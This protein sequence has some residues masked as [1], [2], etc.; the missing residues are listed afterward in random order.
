MRLAIVG[1]ITHLYLETIWPTPARLRS[2]VILNSRSP[3]ACVFFFTCGFVASLCLRDTYVKYDG[4]QQCRT[5]YVYNNTL[6]EYAERLYRWYAF[7][8]MEKK[9]YFTSLAMILQKNV[10]LGVNSRRLIAFM[11]K[12]THL[13]ENTGKNSF[14]RLIFF[15][16]QLL[17]YY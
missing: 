2:K 3:N 10:L 4:I 12:I 7:V 15:F 6:N 5:F 16:F 13:S 11:K 8:V 17:T 14:L 1:W 9:N